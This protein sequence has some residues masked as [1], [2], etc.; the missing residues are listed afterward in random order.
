MDE[1]KKKIA[2]CRSLDDVVYVFHG[3]KVVNHAVILYNVFPVRDTKERKSG[4]RW[5]VTADYHVLLFCRIGNNWRGLPDSIDAAFTLKDKGITYF[6][7][8]GL[9]A[10]HEA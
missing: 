5:K 1:S 7:K 8:V 6:F 9:K 2:F 3:G 4:G 10:M